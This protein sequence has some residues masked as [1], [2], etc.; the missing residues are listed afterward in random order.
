MDPETRLNRMPEGTATAVFHLAPV[1]LEYKPE[2]A[3][4][5]PYILECGTF[6]T[7]TAI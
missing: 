3:L 7:L 2:D 6:A 4:A 1:L 5:E